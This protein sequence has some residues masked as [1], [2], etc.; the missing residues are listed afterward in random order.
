MISASEFSD[1]RPAAMR[2]RATARSYCAAV[3]V[4]SSV[5]LVKPPAFIVARMTA[6]PDAPSALNAAIEAA[7]CAA[8]TASPLSWTPAPSATIAS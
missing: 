7:A 3:A 2:S 1:D 6:W 5:K 8:L 4:A